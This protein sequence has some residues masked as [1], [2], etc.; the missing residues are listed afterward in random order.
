MPPALPPAELATAPEG[1]REAARQAP[2]GGLAVSSPLPHHS[3]PLPRGTALVWL[4]RDLRLDDNPALTAALK[5][6]GTVVRR[7]PFAGRQALSW[8]PGG[9]LVGAPQRAHPVCSWPG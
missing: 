1:G 4:R 6:G 3:P 8:R 2:G 5:T 7:A 9:Q